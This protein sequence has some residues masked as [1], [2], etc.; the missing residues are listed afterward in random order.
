MHH[1]LT[2]HSNLCTDASNEGLGAVLTQE[3]PSG[4]Q[5]IFFLIRKLT[6]PKQ[7]YAVIEREAVAIK[8]ALDYFKYYLWG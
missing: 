7:N 1:F 4:E 2:P 8:W 3:T 5:R 6:K